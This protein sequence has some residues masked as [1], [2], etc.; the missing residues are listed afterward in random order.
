MSWPIGPLPVL[1][2]CADRSYIA[3]DGTF[4]NVTDVY[5][6]GPRI[7]L[8][9]VTFRVRPVSD[10]DAPAAADERVLEMT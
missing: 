10:G 3:A 1:V 9:R 8:A 7:P 6:P 5:T 2:R 4:V